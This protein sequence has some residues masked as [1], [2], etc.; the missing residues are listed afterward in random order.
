MERQSSAWRNSLKGNLD[1]HGTWNQGTR[2]GFLDRKLGPPTRAV[3]RHEHGRIKPFQISHCTL[4]LHII[5]HGKMEATNHG[6]EGY[7]VSDE[8]E[9]ILGRVDDASVAAASKDDYSFPCE[10]EICWN[11][12]F[13]MSV[14]LVSCSPLMLQA[15]KRSSA[16]S[17]SEYQSF[18]SGSYR[19]AFLRPVS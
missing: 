13:F 7:I 14:N 3:S 8:L 10:G 19:T 18:S 11:F 12:I 6:V 16:M 2:H 17:S 1:A 15:R 5:A 4:D 9:C